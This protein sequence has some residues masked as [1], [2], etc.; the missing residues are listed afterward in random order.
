MNKR[1]IRAI[2]LTKVRLQTSGA[3]FVYAFLQN[4]HSQLLVRCCRKSHS[5]TAASALQNSYGSCRQRA[6]DHDVICPC[7]STRR[8]KLW[9]SDTVEQLTY[10]SEASNKLSVACLKSDAWVSFLIINKLINHTVFM[11]SRNF[12]I[13]VF[14]CY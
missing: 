1:K 6:H 3:D 10:Q 8:K 13:V 14:S 2:L 5:Q 11:E 4:I 7:Y 9:W 12:P